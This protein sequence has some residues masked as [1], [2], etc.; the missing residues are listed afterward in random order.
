MTAGMENEPGTSTVSEHAQLE[1]ITKASEAQA[2]QENVSKTLHKQYKSIE[3][4]I[5]SALENLD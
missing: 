4:L 3:C 2:L 1:Q 5:W